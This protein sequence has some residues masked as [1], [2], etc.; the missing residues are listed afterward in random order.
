MV[1]YSVGPVGVGVVCGKVCGPGGALSG[2]RVRSGTKATVRGFGVT[3]GAW[4]TG[5]TAGVLAVWALPTSHRWPCGQTSCRAMGHLARL[6]ERKPLRLSRART[7]K[8][9]NLGIQGGGVAWRYAKY[10]GLVHWQKHQ[11]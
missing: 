1:G 2:S 7:R 6:G 8:Q 4:H 3:A 9:G 5:Q 11:G 10:R